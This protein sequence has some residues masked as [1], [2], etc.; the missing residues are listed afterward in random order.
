MSF[1]YGGYYPQNNMRSPMPQI[2]PVV[3]PAFQQE[4]AAQFRVIPVANPEE[5]TAIPTDFSGIPYLMPDFAHG[6]IYTKTFNSNT[7]ASVFLT[8]RLEENL[9]ANA[10]QPT[11][12]P[13]DAKAEIDKLTAELE[14]I[15]KKLAAIEPEPVQEAKKK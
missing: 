7:G 12:A 15:K 5:A 3:P 8:F 6:A 2:Q 14:N 1:P 4:Q 11:P 13:Y 10:Q 9:Q